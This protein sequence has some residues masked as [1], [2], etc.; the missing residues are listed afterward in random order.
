MILKVCGMKYQDNIDQLVKLNPDWMG[1]I[2]YPRSPRNVDHEIKIQK[3]SLKKIGVFVNE[4]LEAIKHKKEQYNLE[5]IQL[6]GD[7][8][9]EFCS[10]IGKLNVLVIKAFSISDTFNF[11][12]LDNYQ[13][14]CDFFLFDTK[15]EN[16]GG[17]GIPFDW[18]LLKKYQGNIPFLLSGGIRL[19]LLPAIKNFTHSKWVGI[20]INSGFEIEPGLKDIKR[21]KEFK[22]GLSS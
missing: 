21:I 16:R 17:N 5:G 1:L 20:D 6:H 11:K 18:E 8:P 19:E 7:E 14:S 2:F 13:S 9:P 22:D 3:N 12:K 15:G 4:R 10:S